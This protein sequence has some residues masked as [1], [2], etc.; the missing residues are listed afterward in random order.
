MHTRAFRSRSLRKTI[1]VR[2]LADGDTATVRALFERMGDASRAA[3]FHGAKPRLSPAELARLAAVDADRHV[4]VAWVDGDPIPAASARLV[5]NTVDRHVAEI[6]FEVADR[7]Q[8]HGIA[9]AL[10]RILIADARAAGITLVEGLVQPSND[11][12]VN[13]LRRVLG[14]LAMRYEDGAILVSSA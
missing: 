13:L 8:G 14:R 12:A 9:T 6:A 11:A 3:R 1:L 7:Y 10:V 2:P 5:R 4:L